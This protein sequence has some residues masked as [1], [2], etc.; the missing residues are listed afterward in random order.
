MLRSALPHSAFAA[1]FLILSLVQYLSHNLG[2]TP[3]PPA[4]PALM[5]PGPFPERRPRLRAGVARARGRS[6][7]RVPGPLCPHPL[8]RRGR[9]GVLFDVRFVEW[10]GGR[11][12]GGVLEVVAVHPQ[13]E[14]GVQPKPPLPPPDH[15]PDQSD[16]GRKRNWPLEKSDRVIFGTQTVGSQTPSPPTLL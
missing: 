11:E 16:R 13:E 1:L 2:L 14:G 8:R 9:P 15:P 3:P 5:G 10:N 6:I 12:G 7:A 4:Q